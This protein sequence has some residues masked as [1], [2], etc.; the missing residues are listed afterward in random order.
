MAEC[1]TSKSQRNADAE[2]F[3]CTDGLSKCCKPWFSK[4]SFFTIILYHNQLCVSLMCAIYVQGHTFP[5]KSC[6]ILK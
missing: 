1:S 5:T 4:K 6:T 2:V 3:T